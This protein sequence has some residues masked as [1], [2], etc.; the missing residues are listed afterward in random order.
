MNDYFRQ[1]FLFLLGK[2]LGVEYLD[3]YYV[4]V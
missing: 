3:V 2:Y 1:I 4:Y